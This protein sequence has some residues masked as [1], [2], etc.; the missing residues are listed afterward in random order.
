MSPALAG[1]FF[2]FLP[3]CHLGSL[4]GGHT[5]IESLTVFISGE[6][7]QRRKEEGQSIPLNLH[8]SILVGILITSSYFTP[9]SLAIYIF[10]F[11]EQAPNPGPLRYEH[12]VLA[13][14]PA[15]K[16]PALL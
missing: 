13:T 1:E 14:G 7:D 3:Q 15:G 4:E 11:A 5:V 10:K 8:A 9:S 6:K 2:F 12:R 16:F